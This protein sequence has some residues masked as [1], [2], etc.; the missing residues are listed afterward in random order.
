MSRA[1]VRVVRGLQ[2]PVST[3]FAITASEANIIRELDGR[4]VG[5]ALEASLAAFKEAPS[6]NLMAGIS[7]PMR[8]AAT[9]PTAAPTP[10]DDEA[11]VATSPYV[12]RAI[13]GYS[14]QA[15]ALV[16]G[17]SPDLLA[18]PE[19]RLCLH[20]FSADNAKAELAAR[21]EALARRDS[22]APLLGG[23]MVPCLGR[24]AQLYGSD[25][26]E[27]A[28]LREALRGGPG[29]PTAASE[30]ELAGFFAGGEI[31]P[32]GG[33]TFVHTYTTTCGLL[34]AKG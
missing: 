14:K 32:V 20:A 22:A 2:L 34:R 19:A 27:S 26:V 11:G 7:V 9:L 18:Q 30:L 6:G 25:G 31:G 5:E 29:G 17:A 28:V 21:A 8:P 10:L 16:V 12:V 1:C 33:R 24:G 3:S 23:L 13:L 4:P 15:S